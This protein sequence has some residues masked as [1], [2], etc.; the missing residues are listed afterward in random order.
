ML[1]KRSI[2]LILG[3]DLSEKADLIVSEVLSAGF[4]GEGASDAQRS[5]QKRLLKDDGIIIP[6]AGKIRISLIDVTQKLVELLWYPMSVVS[7]CRALMRSRQTGF[8]S[9]CKKSPATQRPRR[10]V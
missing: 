4:V 1:N 8:P 2:D 7:T 5:T 9:T 3:E 10:C 6:Q